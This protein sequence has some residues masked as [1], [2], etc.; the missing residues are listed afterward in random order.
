MLDLYDKVY[1]LLSSKKPRVPLIF[2]NYFQAYKE[3]VYC[4]QWAGC[5]AAAG[6]Q[7]GGGLKERSMAP[8]SLCHAHCCPVTVSRPD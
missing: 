6:S 8:P 3:V 5:Q 1:S 4:L 7:G 2:Y